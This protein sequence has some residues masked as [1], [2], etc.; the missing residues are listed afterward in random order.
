MEAAVIFIVIQ[1]TQ[2]LTQSVWL[3]VHV[4]GTIE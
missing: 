1:Q 4:M 3:N 2:P